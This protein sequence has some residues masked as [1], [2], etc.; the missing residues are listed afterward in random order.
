MSRSI[1]IPVICDEL[2][3]FI[4]YFIC[5]Q[6]PLV[7]LWAFNIHVY[8]GKTLDMAVIDIRNIDKF[9]G[10]TLVALS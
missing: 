8:K 4:N 6:F 7:L 2:I 9:C 10:I 5:N 1:A 3:V